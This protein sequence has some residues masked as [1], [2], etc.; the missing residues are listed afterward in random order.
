MTLLQSHLRWWFAALFFT[1]LPFAALLVLERVSQEAIADPV[2]VLMDENALV[3]QAALLGRDPLEL[4][5]HYQSLGLQGIALYEE[6]IESLSHSG[7][8]VSMLGHEL[9][10]QAAARGEELPAIPG[11]A[12]VIREIV[13]GSA[14]QLLAKNFPAATP[15]QYAGAR[16]WWWPGSDLGQR[17]A[18]PD[19]AKIAAFAEAGFDIAYRPLNFPNL[20]F[21]GDDFPPEARYLI[22][23]KLQVAGHPNLLD[24]TIRA[25]T[26]RLTALIEGSAQDG[27]PLIAG[28]VPS[29]RLLSFDQLYQNQRLSPEDLIAK[30]LLAANERH[31]RLLYIRPY[32][33]EQQGDML[34]NTERLVVGLHRALAHAGFTVA[35][36]EPPSDRYHPDPRYRAIAGAGIVAGAGLLVTTLPLGWGLLVMGGLAGLVLL[37]AGSSW[38]ALALLAALTFPVLGFAWLPWRWWTLPIATLLSLLGAALLVASGSDRNTMLALEPF[39][40]VGATLVIPPALMVLAVLLRH[41]SAATWV[42]RAWVYRPSVGEALVALVALAAIGL[43][44]MRRGNFPIIGASEVELA[45]RSAMSDLFVRPRFKELLG[46]PLALLGLLMGHWPWWAR[47]GLLVAGVV[48]QASILNSFSHYHTPLIVS[49][50]RSMIAL[51]LGVALGL[52]LW[53]LVRGGEWLIRRWLAT[54]EA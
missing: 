54:A 1:S 10:A 50:Q 28:Q 2:M 7:A 52:V 16:W 46:H 34:L 17:P 49:L 45:L 5:I 33:E 4:A 9:R 13:P 29:V 32:T 24:Q 48:A 40:G 53:L 39:I 47:G 23:A 41:G 12:T 36:L 25:S 31:V 15:L 6:T 19:S 11:N 3:K 37:A 18:G 30:Y 27:L 51:A 26:N 21:V 35:P 42:R 14:R 22:H 43:V 38:A 44:F 20:R 8:L